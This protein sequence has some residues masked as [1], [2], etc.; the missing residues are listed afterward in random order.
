MYKVKIKYK[1]NGV[2]KQI[3]LKYKHKSEMIREIEE[4]TKLMH[5][6]YET[7]ELISVLINIMSNRKDWNLWKK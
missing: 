3:N 5:E 7:F 6:E 2:N 1:L 4:S